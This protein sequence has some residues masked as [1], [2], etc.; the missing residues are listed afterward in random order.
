MAYRWGG[1]RGLRPALSRPFS[2]I[3]QGPAPNPLLRAA[4][5]LSVLADAGPVGRPGA[6]SARHSVAYAAS[7]P[8]SLASKPRIKACALEACAAAVKIA[9]LSLL[10]IA[11]QWLK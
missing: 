6:S 11:I 5:D 4:F 9:F 2:H 10:R 8:R 7:C 1:R 3:R